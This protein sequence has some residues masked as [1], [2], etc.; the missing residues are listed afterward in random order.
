MEHARRSRPASEPVNNSQKSIPINT[1]TCP[2]INCRSADTRSPR[3]SCLISFHSSSLVPSAL[4]PRP[5]ITL[6]DIRS[7][8]TPQ[9]VVLRRHIPAFW[10]RRKVFILQNVRVPHQQ[11]KKTRNKGRQALFEM[12][13]EIRNSEA[14]ILCCSVER[15]LAQVRNPAWANVLLFLIIHIADAVGVCISCAWSPGR[16]GHPLDPQTPPYTNS[17]YFVLQTGFKL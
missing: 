1:D 11:Q 16:V 7:I 15:A 3:S 10:R 17:K 12:E 2:S 8:P 5:C 4:G 9:S 6:R 14:V 13:M